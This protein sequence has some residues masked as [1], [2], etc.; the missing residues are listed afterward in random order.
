[1]K[2]DRL[3]P[4]MSLYGSKWRLAPKYPPPLYDTIIEP[5]AGAAGYS[6]LHY[7]RNVILV[8]RD[9]KI[10]GVWHYLLNVSAKELGALRCNI[11]HVDELGAV[12]QEARWLVGFWMGKAN[13]T[14]RVQSGNWA[15]KYSK[16]S[17]FWD[18]RTKQRLLYSLPKIH[19]WKL[20]QGNFTN[21]PKM[22]ATWFV[23]PPYQRA[24][25]RYKFGSNLLDFV[26]LGEW[27][28]ELPGQVMVC[29]NMGATWLPF[30]IFESAYRG[31]RKHSIEA[32]WCNGEI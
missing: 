31:V 1:M 5:F 14:P 6:L 13:S 16:E 4:V 26:K 21:S 11:Q 27:C 30:E 20:I 23:D 19:H 9:P 7:K 10:A 22:P 28:K 25:V 24:G 2:L 18:E 29:E 8:E 15:V 3:P 32:I 17:Y 12:P